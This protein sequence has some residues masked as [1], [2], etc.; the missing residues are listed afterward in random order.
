MNHANQTNRI[1]TTKT[2]RTRRETPGF[3]FNA[4]YRFFEFFAP[5]WFVSLIRKIR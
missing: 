5:S 3:R 2:Q 4:D 1:G